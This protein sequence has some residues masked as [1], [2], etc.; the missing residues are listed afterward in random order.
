MVEARARWAVTPSLQ[1]A[2]DLVGQIEYALQYVVAGRDRRR[3]IWCG[4]K[5]WRTKRAVPI[6]G[7]RV[8][9]TPKTSV[10]PM[11]AF[12]STSI[13]SRAILSGRAGI[14]GIVI[15]LPLAIALMLREAR[16]IS[17]RACWM[18]SSELERPVDRQR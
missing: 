1:H 7:N 12:V 17:L 4:L 5:T 10:W 14:F 6:L 2:F 11:R 9:D 13:A 3:L 8:G 18:T 16:A 15:L